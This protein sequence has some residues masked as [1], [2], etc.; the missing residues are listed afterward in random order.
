M[1]SFRSKFCANAPRRDV[2]AH[3]AWQ[4]G[5]ALLR[6]PAPWPFYVAAPLAALSGALTVLAFAPFGWWPVALLAVM[7]WYQTLH[8]HGPRTAF[9]LGWLFGLGLFGCG[10]SWIR[11]SLDEF[12]NL[13]A[14]LA[15]GFT[16]AFIGLMALYYGLNGWLLYRLRAS[17]ACGALLVL[18]GVWTLSEWLR[19][20]LFTGFPWLI[21]GNTQI[22]GPLAGWVPVLG[23]HGASFAV[24]GAAGLLWWAWQGRRRWPLGALLLLGLLG[25]ALGRM[26]WTQ[27][28]GAPLSVALVQANIAQ[29]TKWDPER[30]MAT[31]E[32]HIVLTRPHLGAAVI[33][34]P[35]TA[36]PDFLHRVRDA[37]I[38][39]L[40]AH[41]RAR[42]SAV[43][44]GIPIMNPDRSYYNSLLAIGSR[45]DR[46]DKRH[47]V[48]F[49]EFLPFKR[50]LEPLIDWFA[51]PMSD[52]SRGTATRPVLQVGDHA[53]GVSI[54]YED[55]FPD[56]VRQ[57]LPEARYLLNV[58]NDAWFGDSLAPHQHLEFARLRALENG[59]F[60]VRATNTGISAVID[61]RG[62]IRARL[63]MFVADTL[64]ATVQPH[65]GMTPF[66][67]WGSG[68]AV[69]IALLSVAIGVL[70]AHRAR[71]AAHRPAP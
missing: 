15:D 37:V 68:V 60:L 25:W 33:V 17:G 12:G 67:R 54:C 20:W 63:P 42:G 59:R 51:V 3:W 49:G 16:V 27:P 8:G 61:Q 28:A 52:F 7:L 36:V 56:E 5:W 11:I 21:L 41:A 9:V 22:D 34:W 55:T 58:S 57:A 39:P 69:G 46:Y 65:T 71:D 47:L 31:V 62:R 6:T 2:V 26:A 64:V 30:L 44:I 70:S 35:E 38:E 1:R 43:V 23:V 24:V 53:V 40:A 48:P 66:A 18:P 4:Q 19:G 14:M 10:I 45:E 13:P 29:A 32:A 50:W